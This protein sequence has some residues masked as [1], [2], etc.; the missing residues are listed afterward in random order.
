MEEPHAP[1]RLRR[2]RYSSEDEPHGALRARAPQHRHRPHLLAALRAPAPRR[3]TQGMPGRGAPAVGEP[4]ALVLDVAVALPLLV[5]GCLLAPSCR[6][7][8]EVP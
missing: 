7:W 1:E 4:V 3:A 8:A 6:R 5:I 2:A